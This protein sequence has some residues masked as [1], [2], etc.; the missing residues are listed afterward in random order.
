MQG[1]N[2]SVNISSNVTFDQNVL[3]VV[4]EGTRVDIGEDCIFA[5]GVTIRTSDQHAIYNNDNMRINKAKN[6][7]IGNHVW[8]G[9]H[10]IVMKGTEVGDGSVIGMNSMITKNIPIN[11]IAVGT[12]AKPIKH[13]IHW[14]KKL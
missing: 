5:N 10:V 4:C 1:D 2:N 8:L 14:N 13:N 11:C 12:P 3:L 7:K 9:A 6:V